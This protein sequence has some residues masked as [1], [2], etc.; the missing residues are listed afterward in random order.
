MRAV[1]AQAE[2]GDEQQRTDPNVTALCQEVAAALGHEAA[3]FLP[4]GTMCNLVGVATHVAPGDTVVMEHLG[5]IL[6][7]ETGGIGAVSG[8]VVD[9]IRGER[10]IFGVPELT[11]ALEPG[12]AYRPSPT[13]VCLEQTHNFG[14]GSVWPLDTYGAVV[15]AAHERGVKVHLDGAR[16]FNAVVASGVGADRVGGTGRQRLGRLHQGARCSSRRRARRSRRVHRT[17]VAVE[18]PARRGDAPGGHRRRGV[19]LCPRPPRR[20]PRRRPRQGRT[21]SQ[22]GSPPSA[23]RSSPSTRTWC[24]CDRRRSGCPRRRSL[25]ACDE[26]GVR[27]SHVGD[28]VRAVTHLDVDDAG[29]ELALSAAAATIG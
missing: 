18:A 26:H 2:V 27:V 3:I 1:M 21:T 15:G 20:A 19:P 9:T 28:R 13:L 25:Q 23:S 7:S 29:I 10:G 6:R 8:A 4:T 22:P 17:G 14:G 5:H 24:G 11:A 16:L 12:N